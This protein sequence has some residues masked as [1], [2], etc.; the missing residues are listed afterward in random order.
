[1]LKYE[2]EMVD[3]KRL[4]EKQQKIDTIIASL[5]AQQAEQAEIDDVKQTMSEIEANQMKRLTNILKK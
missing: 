2:Q 4:I 1:M 5:I 3:N